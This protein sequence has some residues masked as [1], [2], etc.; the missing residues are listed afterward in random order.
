M[1][2]TTYLMNEDEVAKELDCSRG[3]AYKIIG[4]MNDELKAKGYYIISGKIP[5]AFLEEKFF[6]FTMK[7]Q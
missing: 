5:R 2:S 1:M 7:A 3:H 4:S 6:G